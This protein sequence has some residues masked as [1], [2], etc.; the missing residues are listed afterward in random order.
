VKNIDK[1]EAFKIT[2]LFNTGEIKVIDLAPKLKEWTT[3][4]DS[5]YKQLLN[6]DYFSKV[7]LNKELETICWENGIDF[8]PD[9]LYTWAE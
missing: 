8:C 3:S 6:P 9:T 1:V 5:K 4:P 2:L 7:Q